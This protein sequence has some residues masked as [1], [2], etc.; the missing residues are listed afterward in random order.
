MKQINKRHKHQLLQR[1]MDE[2]LSATAQNEL[3]QYQETEEGQQYTAVHTRL[4]EELR[5]DNLE[6][7]LTR[8]Q[9]RG[10]AAKIEVQVQQ[11]RRAQRIR[12]TRQSVALAAAVVLT[13]LLIGSWLKPVEPEPVVPFTQPT[14]TSAALP[15]ETAVPTPTL[16]PNM[17]FVD[18]M[19]MSPQ[20]LASLPPDLYTLSVPAAAATVPYDLWLPTQLNKNFFLVGAMVNPETQSVEIALTTSANTNNLFLLWVFSQKPVTSDTP[21]TPLPTIYQPFPGTPVTI[22]LRAKEEVSLYSTEGSFAAY[23]HYPS[24][25]DWLFVNTLTWQEDNHQFTLT[26]IAPVQFEAQNMINMAE[27]FHLMPAK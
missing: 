8:Q 21:N 10:I 16:V 24:L 26:L 2:P 19:T 12:Q 13:I 20:P 27:G 5:M 11:K 1:A 6:P 22:T 25:R 4:R 15:T 3:R 7:H 23:E 17:I 14:T 18:M 9:L